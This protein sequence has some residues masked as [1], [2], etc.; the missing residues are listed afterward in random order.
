M[1]DKIKILQSV[2][3]LGIGGNEIFVMNFYRQLDKEKF[4]IDFVI[5]DDTR[6][7]LYEQIN[8]SW[9]KVFICKKKFKNKYIQAISEIRQVKKILDREHYD[10]I[11]CH[12]C[13]FIGILRGAIPGFMTKG[14]KV[15]SHAHNPGKPK[16]TI[17]D[18]AIRHLTKKLLSHISDLGFACS[19]E[20]GNSKYTRSFQKSSRYAVIRNAIDTE[21]FLFDECARKE[22]RKHYGIENSFVIGSVG[23]LEE[24]KNFLFLV[25]V[26]AEYLKVNKQCCLLLVGDGKQK[27]MIMERAKNEGIDQHLVLA[28]LTEHPEKFYSAM[29]VFA[30]PSIYEGFGLVNIEAQV[31]GLACVVS[32][33]IPR[34]ADISGKVDFLPF[35]VS[36]WCK[37]LEKNR[38][39]NHFSNRQSLYTKEYDIHSE[40]LRLESFYNNICL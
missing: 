37:M 6:L 29:D 40:V 16:G 7:N 20:C 13:S 5:Y 12:S 25:D 27:E 38:V 22:K 26:L 2:N 10:I 4:Q 17:F 9:S 11:H 34:E 35:D 21:K 36:Q 8:K 24:Q 18:N 23:R 19:E 3:S 14:T 30:L 32:Q 15:I 33:A 39:N 28:G 31:S 1:P